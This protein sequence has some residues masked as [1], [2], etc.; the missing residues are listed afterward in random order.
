MVGFC[1]PYFSFFHVFF[2][3]CRYGILV[4]DSM[5]V[6]QAIYTFVLGAVIIFTPS[7]DVIGVEL[8]PKRY[9]ANELMSVM[10]PQ[11]IL[12]P[13]VQVF[14]LWVLSEQSFYVRFTTDDP[15]SSAYSYEATVIQNILLAQFMIASVVS[16][17]G[18]PFKYVSHVVIHSPCLAFLAASLDSVSECT[19][20]RCKLLAAR[21][22]S[23]NAAPK[24][25]MQKS[26]CFT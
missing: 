18:P 7:L 23:R 16:T 3:L 9:F 8:P 24:L 1:S 5:F 10:I 20:L 22:S 17:I 6:V 15:L 13:L 25:Q 12:F 26:P 21:F 4:S 11:F 14:G 19:S 2:P